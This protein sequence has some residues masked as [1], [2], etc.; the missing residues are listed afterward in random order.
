MGRLIVLLLAAATAFASEGAPTVQVMGRA[1]S[2]TPPQRQSESPAKLTFFSDCKTDASNAPDCGPPPAKWTSVDNPVPFCTSQSGRPFTVDADEFRAL[3]AEAA[4]VW[5][6]Q[7]AAVSARISGDCSAPSQQLMGNGRS[8]IAWEPEVDVL[9]DAGVAVT[10]GRWRLVA[11]EKRFVETD[12]VLSSLYLGG[13]PLPCLRAVILHELGHALGLGHSDT[14]NDLMYARF[15]PADL[16][17]CAASPSEE[18]RQA[19]QSLYGVR[20]LPT[21]SRVPLQGTSGLLVAEVMSS[22]GD[23]VSALGAAGCRAEVVGVV[24]D[25]RWLLYIVR[26]PQQVNAAFP[27]TMP[28]GSPFYVR[29]EG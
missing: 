25:G 15:N 23:L 13:I 1:V 26:A 22:V 14:V 2:L 5:G 12:I 28:A 3:A 24:D 8:E 7:D 4:S 29:C 9:Y 19:L 11:G 6:R 20:R 21:F 17:T 16:D 18:D 10:I 27:P